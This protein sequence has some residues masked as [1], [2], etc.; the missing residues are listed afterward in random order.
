M[1]H[2]KLCFA[3]ELIA[4]AAGAFISVFPLILADNY[5]AAIWST[6]TMTWI[7]IA[8]DNRKSIEYWRKIVDIMLEEKQHDAR[9]I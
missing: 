4:A 1:K 8:Q 3:F 9:R 2:S 5:Q 7:A 6:L